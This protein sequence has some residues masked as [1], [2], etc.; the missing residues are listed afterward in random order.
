MLAIWAL[1]A[2][3]AATYLIAVSVRPA[4]LEGFL[5]VANS[6]LAEAATRTDAEIVNI[7]DSVGQLQSDVAKVQSDLA[8]HAGRDQTL[9]DRVA[10]LEHNL[11]GNPAAAAA[12]HDQGPGHPSSALRTGSTT[13]EPRVLNSAPGLETGSVGAD[14]PHAAPAQAAPKKEAA[15]PKPKP[16]GI[17][18]AAGPSVDHLRD[19]WNVLSGRH[20][21][22][23][24]PLEPRYVNGA[25]PETV[26]LVAG[27]FKSPAEAKKICK[28]LQAEAIACS[29]SNFGGK[30][31]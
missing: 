4:F 18:L 25:D 5:P 7:R 3:L 19:S 16:V 27:P 11:Q 22:Q 10:A 15:A 20:A 23:L 9:E 1:M 14:A 2:S 28:E 29:V 13:G 26:D 21:A 8:S 12:P 31:L 17:K 30:K 6:Q 24:A